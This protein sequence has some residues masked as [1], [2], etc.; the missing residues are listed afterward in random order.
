MFCNDYAFWQK[1]DYIH[2][3]IVIPV[4][5]VLN[6]ICIVIFFKIVK[7]NRNRASNLFEY[8]FLKS[9]WDFFIFISYCPILIYVDFDSKRN[10][11]FIMQV[12][13]KWVEYYL[14]I[15]LQLLSVIF[16]VLASLDCLLLVTRRLSFLKTRRTFYIITLISILFCFTFY[17]PNLFKNV[18]NL[19]YNNSNITLINH[20]SEEKVYFV[21]WSKF[22]SS[23]FAKYHYIVHYILR[24]IVALIILC[25]INVLILISLRNTT[26]RKKKLTII[27][28]ES[29]NAEKNKINMILFTGIIYL[30]HVPMIL[31]NFEYFFIRSCYGVVCHVLFNISNSIPIVS[32]IL[33][34]RKFK[35]ILLKFINF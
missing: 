13:V 34:N 31:N 20:Q 27:A 4:G 10:T 18:I 15:G 22:F 1:I 21:G 29:I 2:Y 16:E 23:Q 35:K 26:K 8:L 25:V 14:I 6:L 24:D 19:K 3:C 11:S 9:F 5:L 33:F 17:I 28:I 7:E 32:Y 12:W 30:L